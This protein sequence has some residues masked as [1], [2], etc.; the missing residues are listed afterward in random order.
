MT[1]AVELSIQLPNQGKSDMSL[2]H[3]PVSSSSV[4]A[5]LCADAIS[6]KVED[7]ADG[8]R[9]SG[10]CSKASLHAAATIAAQKRCL[11]CDSDVRSSCTS[12]ICVKGM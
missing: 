2:Q 9:C 11:Q 12:K 7:E 6:E 10:N 3:G 5:Q 1:T 4:L 8:V